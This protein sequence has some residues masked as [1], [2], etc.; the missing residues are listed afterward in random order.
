MKLLS[1]PDS[2]EA[3]LHQSLGAFTGQVTVISYSSGIWSHQITQNSTRDAG[4]AR[5][6]AELHHH[7]RPIVVWEH[8]TQQEFATLCHKAHDAKP[9]ALPRL[10]IVLAPWVSKFTCDQEE[11]I[12]SLALLE[13]P[14]YKLSQAM[15][16][17]CCSKQEPT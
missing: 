8:A 5:I 3:A 11:D 17:S 15:Q 14:D 6:W 12:I 2:W 4:T 7:N 16:P 1:M 13:D 9:Q 10:I